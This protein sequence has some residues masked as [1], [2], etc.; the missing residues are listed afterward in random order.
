MFLMFIIG[1]AAA[2]IAYM[3]ISIAAL[4]YDESLNDKI[5]EQE[6]CYEHKYKPDGN[7]RTD[8]HKAKT[9]GGS[10]LDMG[11]LADKAGR[12]NTAAQS[13]G[14]NAGKVS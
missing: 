3:L 4:K 10:G 1:S 2:V 13:S 12:F 14:R 6:G 11:R 9:G 7:R 5:K 8:G